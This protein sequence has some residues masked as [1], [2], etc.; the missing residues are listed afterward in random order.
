MKTWIAYFMPE[1]EY[2]EKQMLYFFAEGATVLLLFMVSMLI[3][4]PFFKINT[5][6][7]LFIG[8]AIFLFYILGRYILSGMEYT[9]V[10][11]A[12]QYK[13]EIKSLLS[14][15]ASYIVIFLLLHLIYSLLSN[16]TD[17]LNAIG[18][19]ITFGAVFFLFNFLSLKQS[20]QKNKDLL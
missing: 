5:G 18:M 2:K 13:K 1:D 3:I 11:T 10:A 7:T 17:W 19:G 4:N 14:R 6:I 15:T 8:I 20:Y 16:K 12:G 9:E